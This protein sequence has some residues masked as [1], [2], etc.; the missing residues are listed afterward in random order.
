MFPPRAKEQLYS[1]KG[2]ILSSYVRR[3]ENPERIAE[4]YFPNE[5]NATKI[6]CLQ[7]SYRNKDHRG[8]N[9]EPDIQ[10]LSTLHKL[11]RLCIIESQTKMEMTWT[12][13]VSILRNLFN[14]IVLYTEV[15]RAEYCVWLCSLLDLRRF[16]S[17]QQDSLDGG[18]ARSKAATY[19]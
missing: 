1:R 6:A 17:S 12:V 13:M 5:K 15:M 10:D 7:D 14:T 2:Q 19:I 16:F 8:F 9:Y 3:A 11:Q 18:S 4:T